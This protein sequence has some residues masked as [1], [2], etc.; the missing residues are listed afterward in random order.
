MIAR[1]LASMKAVKVPQPED[2]ADIFDVQAA[3]MEQQEDVATA[4]AEPKVKR[5]RKE[6][7]KRIPPFFLFV[8]AMQATVRPQ[9]PKFQDYQAHL[10]ELWRNM[11]DVARQPYVDQAAEENKHFLE[12]FNAEHGITTVS[13]EAEDDEAQPIEVHTSPVLF[14]IPETPQ[15]TSMAAV[16]TSMLTASPIVMGDDDLSEERKKKKK[17]KKHKK[18]KE[19]KKHKKHSLAGSEVLTSQ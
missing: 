15:R 5:Q 19:H 8:K 10:A 2:H 14:A 11:D 9:F 7:P 18:D 12:A 1:A 16:D 13:S 4:T 17:D 3:L 6:R